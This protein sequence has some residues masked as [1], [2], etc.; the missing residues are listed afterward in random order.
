MNQVS[1]HHQ[2]RQLYETHAKLLLSLN[3]HK[4]LMPHPLEVRKVQI[5]KK[6]KSMDSTQFK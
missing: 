5:E 4:I 6:N 2:C 3:D 1:P